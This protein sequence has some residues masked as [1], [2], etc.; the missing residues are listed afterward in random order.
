M[1]GVLHEHHQHPYHRQAVQALE[2]RDFRQCIDFCRWFWQRYTD[3]NHFPSMVLYSNEAMFSRDGY[4]NAHNSHYWAVDNPHITRIAH[5][6]R[7]WSINTWA[8]IVD[9]NLIGPYLLP[10]YLD[11]YSYRQ[12][13]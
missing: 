6:Q 5:H 11:G 12:F 13:L 4:F 10:D 2:A 8:G 9:N 7:K 3:D 1:W